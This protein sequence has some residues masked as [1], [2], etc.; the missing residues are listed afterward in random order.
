[1]VEDRRRSDD[2]EVEPCTTRRAGSAPRPP[3][4]CASCT[5]GS[6]AFA[7]AHLL[8]YTQRANEA[9]TAERWGVAAFTGRSA[10]AAAAARAAGRP[11]HAA[12]PLARR[13]T[14]PPTIDALVAVHDGADADAWREYFRRPEVGVVT[15][16]V[17][18]AGYRRTST[19]GLDRH[20]PEVARDIA[21]LRAGGRCRH[22][23]RPPRRRAARAP[24]GGHRSDRRR[25]LRQP[26]RQRPRGPPGH[27]RP[28]V[29]GRPV[30]RRLDRAARLLRVHD[31]RPDHA[32]HHRGRPGGRPQAHRARG[33]VAGGHRAVQ[34]VGA[35]G[36]LP[37]R[38][39]AVGGRRC[40][41]RRRPRAVRAP[42][43]L[44][45]ERRPLPARLRGPGARSDHGRRRVRRPDVPRRAR[46]AVV[47]GRRGPDAPRGRRDRRAA[48]AV[49]ERPHRAPARADRPG[50]VRQA[51]RPHPR[52]RPGAGRRRAARRPG[53]RR[54]RRRVDRP[55]RREPPPTP[56]P[57]TWWHA[58]RVRAAPP[59]PCS[60]STRSPPASP[61]RTSSPGTCPSGSPSAVPPHPPSQEP[62]HEDRHRRRH[63]HQPE[64]QLRHP[65]DHDRRGADRARGRH[66][67]RPRARRR[68]LPAGPRRAA[69]DRPRRVPHRG[70]LAVPLPQRVL[71][72]RPGDHGRDRRRRHGA[73]GHQ[74]QGRADAGLPA[75]RGSEPRRSDGLRPRVRDVAARAVRLHPRAPGAGLPLDPRAD[76]RAGPQV[77]LRHRAP[78]PTSGGAVRPRARPARR[79]PGRGGLGHPR[80][81]APPA[82]RVRGRAQRVRPRPAAAARRAPPDDPDPGGEAGQVPRAVRPVLARGLH[83]GGEPGGPAPG[84][85]AHHDARWRSA[86][87]STPSGTSRRSSRSSSSTTSGPPRRTSGGSARCARSWTTPRSTR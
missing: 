55:P 53:R 11:V 58:C 34:R 2:Q 26:A 80:L 43:A 64:P 84:P 63:R 14:H 22:G 47:R 81:P 68:Q 6:G 13:A 78:S 41:V 40:A 18:E 76:R 87:S 65:Q 60:P 62:D 5:S 69:A 38:P 23:A 4:R 17:T 25:Q 21:R 33:P 67:E 32:R 37:G 50:R 16:T 56:V 86:R 35:P 72:P 59:A 19:G 29:G 7:R 85:P 20:D 70:H 45:A 3:H 54:R 30:A 44:A 24:R 52:R 79:L 66:P 83:P 73:V 1:M 8:W 61:A 36:R 46:A 15:L 74:G 48:R 9:G 39:A 57:P 27:P 42:Q 12:G 28:G 31:G 10:A 82:D 71:A 77:D 75:A 51:P 49:R